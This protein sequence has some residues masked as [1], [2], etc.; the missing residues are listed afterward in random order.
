M[1]TRELWIRRSAQSKSVTVDLVVGRV[2]SEV[3]GD[4]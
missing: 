2:D 1:G 3:C 4:W